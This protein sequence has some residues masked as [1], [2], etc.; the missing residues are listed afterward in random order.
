MKLEHKDKLRRKN[1]KLRQANKKKILSKK[2]K[3][4]SYGKQIKMK[5]RNPFKGKL[6]FD[7]EDT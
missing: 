7:K 1:R 4:T 5:L 6:N 3:T 2:R